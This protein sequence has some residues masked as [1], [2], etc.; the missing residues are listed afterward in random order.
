MDFQYHIL[1]TRFS[2]LSHLPFRDSTQRQYDLQVGNR[3]NISHHL[4]VY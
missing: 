2:I 3:S 4:W 1:H